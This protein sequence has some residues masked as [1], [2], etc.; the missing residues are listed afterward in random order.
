MRILVGIEGILALAILVGLF[1]RGRMRLSM[2]F[3]A[4]A[5]TVV[6]AGVWAWLWPDALY[7]WGPWMAFQTVQVT[8]KLA[9]LFEL[10]AYIFR[11]FPGALAAV[12]GV[13]VLVLGTTVAALL[14]L[15]VSG[16]GLGEFALQ[17]APVA[18]QGV[19][20]GFALLLGLSTWYF[21][22]MDSWRRAIL[23]G[24]AIYGMLF[25]VVLAA[26]DRFG[27]AARELVSYVNMGAYVMLLGYW[28]AAAWRKATEDD[29]NVDRL[30]RELPGRLAA[31]EK[32]A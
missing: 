32:R 7:K 9:I 6:A 13:M 10:G 23:V 17:A 29:D 8:L 30:R 18:N 20:W 16:R 28:N 19:A 14:R 27:G 21:V 1:W 24:M 12:Q 22:P 11:P 15:H 25:T 5:L 2:S 31:R 3:V 26:V 4:Y